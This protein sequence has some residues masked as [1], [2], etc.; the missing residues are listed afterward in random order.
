MSDVSVGVAA[1]LSCRDP[2]GR[3]VRLEDSIWHTKICVD[4]PYMATELVAVREAIEAPDFIT[5]DRVFTDRECYYRRGVLQG[6]LARNYVRVV[7]SFAFNPAAPTYQGFILTAHP[8][9]KVHP[10]E[11]HK[12]P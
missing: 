6:R 10:Q 3:T 8:I 2:L 7:V 9:P 4:H 12:W 1:L 5:F 11:R